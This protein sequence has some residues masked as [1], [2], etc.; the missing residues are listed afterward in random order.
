MTRWTLRLIVANVVMYFLTDLNPRIVEQL[1]LV[2]AQ[3]LYQPWTA[4]TSMFVHGGPSHLFWN[5]LSLFFFGPRVES[6]L[7]D[8][9]FLGL[10]FV[11]GI[12][13][14]ILSLFSPHV[15]IIG[16][17]GA[18]F[19]VML[20]YAIFWPHDKILL[21]FVLPVPAFVLIIL[22]TVMNLLPAISSIG[23]G[24]GIAHFAHLGG[25]LGGYLYLR[26][27]QA[28]SPAGSFRAKATPLQRKSRISSGT[29]DLQRWSSIPRDKM[30]EVNREE[31]DRIL[32]KISAKGIA[33]LTAGEREV[34][35]R[36][37]T[38]H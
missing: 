9:H 14:G 13:G 23:G 35:D 7:G 20:A 32:D 16:A 30:H 33:S 18:I 22:M 21:W 26:W 28:R 27:I 19:G 37:S 8:R 15:P 12:M 25:F 6:R 24:D 1:W 36:F 31:V 2:P 11:S 3:L 38:Q 29:A 4:I 5:M 34:L 17:S 10:Y